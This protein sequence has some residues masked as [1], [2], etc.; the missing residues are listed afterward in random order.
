MY[1]LKFSAPA[2][3]LADAV[4]YYIGGIGAALL[5]D[6]EDTVRA[7]VPRSGVVVAT[8]LAFHQAGAA[9]QGA[10]AAQTATLSLMRNN[11]AIALDAAIDLAAIADAGGQIVVLDAPLS[12]VLAGDLLC[13]RLLI[14]TMDTNPTAVNLSGFVLID[15]DVQLSDAEV[16]QLRSE[17]SLNKADATSTA[18]T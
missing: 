11:T 3:T 16:S 2:I 12:Q 18:R 15:E 14:G 5:T 13:F 8:S 1:S 9:T 10:T 4:T 6:L 7:P 17:V